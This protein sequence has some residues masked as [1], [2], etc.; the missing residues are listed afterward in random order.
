M[1]NAFINRAQIIMHHRSA[2][3]AIMAFYAVLH[4]CVFSLN[5]FVSDDYIQRTYA[6]GSPELESTGLLKGIQA[7]DGWFF[8]NN[9][10]N[11]FDPQTGNDVA[12]REY[13]SLPWWTNDHAM[14]H[15]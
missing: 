4:V 7:N 13:G 10:F 6:T 12:M 5:L 15:L 2:L 9:Q 14:L 1:I 3:F 11:F 8:I